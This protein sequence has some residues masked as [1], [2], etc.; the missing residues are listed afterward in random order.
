MGKRLHLIIRVLAVFLILTEVFGSS[1]NREIIAVFGSE[2]EET[3]SINYDMP[4]LSQTSFA[5]EIGNWSM[6]VLNVTGFSYSQS[7]RAAM[8]RLLP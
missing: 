6:Q 4:G 1:L 7:L 8:V 5:P 3:G 2:Y